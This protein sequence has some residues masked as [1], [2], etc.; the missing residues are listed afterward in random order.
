MSQGYSGPPQS[1]GGGGG[2][3][4]VIV[5]VVAGV[6]GLGCLGVCGLGMLGMTWGVQQATEAVHQAGPMIEQSMKAAMLQ[7]QAQAAVENSAEVKERLGAPLN[8]EPVNNP[9]PAGG[10][11][12]AF[13]FQVTGSKDKGEVHVEARREGTDWKITTLQV[14][15]SDGNKIDINIDQPF[16][17]PLDG[18]VTP[19][20]P[21]E[22][23]DPP[24]STDPV[25]GETTP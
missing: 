23:T 5:L 21:P 16:G 1:S 3:V 19:V 13:D 25:P 2:T 6:L 20:F 15:L 9:P 18:E 4:L 7:L 10:D 22:I 12:T 8:F 11:T 24:Q 14:R 17:I